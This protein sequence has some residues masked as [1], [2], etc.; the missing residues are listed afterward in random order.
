MK[1][2]IFT[3]TSARAGTL[4]LSHVFRNNISDCICRHEPFFDWGNPTMFGR[5][6]YDAYT[7]R[8]ERVRALLQKKRAYIERLAGSLYLESS[9]AFLKSSYVAALEVFP[10]LELIRVIR[11]PLKVARSEAYREDWR[12]RVHAPFHFY[13]GDDHRRHFVWALTGNEPIFRQFPAGALTT[14]QWYL[15]QWIE[16]ENRA[17]RFLDEHNLHSRCFTLE[18]PELSHPEK[19]KAVFDF[20]G[21]RTAKSS[22]V[23]AG[24][25]N[26]SIGYSAA[27]AEQQEAEAAAILR[28][29]PASYLAIFDREPYTNY[30]WS[31]RLRPA[32]MPDLFHQMA[33]SR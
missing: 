18:T 8:V 22:L 7:G 2:T 5:A 13:E 10:D 33:E 30:P 17:A 20:F 26:R 27:K 19:L 29:V 6:V 23:L 16:I 24:R 28:K 14:F 21:L 25:K 31:K 4:Y 1:R 32:G 9:H 11:D 3:L 15:L 12:R